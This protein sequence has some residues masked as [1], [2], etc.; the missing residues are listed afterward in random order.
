[1]NTNVRIKNKVI[2]P[3]LSYKIIG[4]L[5][6]VHNEIGGG[7]KEKYIQNAIEILL[8]KNK[9]L[10]Q[11][12]LLSPLMFKEK[13]IGKYYLDF[14]IDSKIILEIKVGDRFKRTDINQ[15]YSYLKTN[16]LK[17]GIIANFTKNK[18]SFKRILNIK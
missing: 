16:N 8:Q 6:D 14:L 1:M 9:I 5:F 15:I 4:L 7:H 10:Y 13:I 12:E 17:L 2:Y 11:R 18:L 3:E